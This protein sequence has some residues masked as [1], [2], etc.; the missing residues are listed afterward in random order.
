MSESQNMAITVVMAKVLCVLISM[1]TGMGI[2]RFY[3]F[4]RQLLLTVNFAIY[5][6]PTLHLVKE[7]AKYALVCHMRLISDRRMHIDNRNPQKYKGTIRLLT[8]RLVIRH[9]YICT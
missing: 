6:S 7:K 2:D 4:V 3:P 9:S 5:L 1:A 8:F